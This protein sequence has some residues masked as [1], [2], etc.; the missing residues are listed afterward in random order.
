MVGQGQLKQLNAWP[1]PRLITFC[2]WRHQ[3]WQFISLYPQNTCCGVFRRRSLAVSRFSIKKEGTNSKSTFISILLATKSNHKRRI[4]TIRY[5]LGVDCLSNSMYFQYKTILDFT[6]EAKLISSEHLTEVD[7]TISNRTS[8]NL[9]RH[10]WQRM[11]L[12][13]Q[14]LNYLSR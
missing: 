5:L 8:E 10:S 2:F 4:N 3:T 12:E 1:A 6:V 13:T 9:A 7:L 11:L 14:P